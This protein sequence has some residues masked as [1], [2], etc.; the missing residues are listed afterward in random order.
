M[1]I[2]IDII[3]EAQA[4]SFLS[5]IKFRGDI[6]LGDINDFKGEVDPHVFIADA[7]EVSDSVIEGYNHSEDN[8]TTSSVGYS[9]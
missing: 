7:A 5:W 1:K 3:D 6:L 4:E 9:E 8:S 2:L